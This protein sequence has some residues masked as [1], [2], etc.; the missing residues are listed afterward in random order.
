MFGLF[1]PLKLPMWLAIDVVLFVSVSADVPGHTAPPSG[2]HS[3]PPPPGSLL[4]PQTPLQGQSPPWRYQEKPG[5]KKNANTSSQKIKKKC[6]G[7]LI[8]PYREVVLCLEVLQS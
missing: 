8:V 5:K 7:I 6:N 4:W 1:N 2:T 3:T